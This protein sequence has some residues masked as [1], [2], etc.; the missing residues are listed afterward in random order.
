M[1]IFLSWARISTGLV[2]PRLQLLTTSCA[3]GPPED[4]IK[5]QLAFWKSEVGPEIL[6]VRPLSSVVVLML[7]VSEDSTLSSR[8]QIM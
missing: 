3:Y 7:N 4:L 1:Q 8:S 6:H 5:M 2:V